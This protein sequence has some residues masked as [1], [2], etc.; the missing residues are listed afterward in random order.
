LQKRIFFL[1]VVAFA[2]WFLL[3]L[4]NYRKTSRAL[5]WL[6]LFQVAYLVAAVMAVKSWPGLLKGLLLPHI[7]ATPGYTLGAIAIFGSLLTP[8]VLVWQTSSRRDRKAAGGGLHE[9]ESKA[10]TFVAILISLSAVIAASALH[11]ADPS[12]MSTLDA[13]QA[14]RPLGSLA[15]VVFSI[16]IIGSGLIALPIL[17]ASMCFSIAEAANWK[18]GLSIPAWEARRFYVLISAAVLVAAFID[19]GRINT[20]TV[21]YWSQIVAGVLTIPVLY[22]ILLLGNNVRLMGRKNSNF[23]NFWL[24]GAVG[25]M[26]AANALFVWMLFL[27]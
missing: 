20:V 19:F 16:G 4:G 1:P 26:I 2:V 23:E 27:Q 8:D 21:L 22:F 12:H 5:V 6:A 15:P 25:G 14:L 9:G 7:A 24:G 3:V 18:S 13:A 11:V 10:G 17:V